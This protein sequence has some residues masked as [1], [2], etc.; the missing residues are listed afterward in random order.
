M[1][2]SILQGQYSYT[3]T[4]IDAVLYNNHG[5]IGKVG[6][7][8]FNGS[9]VCRDDAIIYQ[10]HLDLNWDIRLGSRSSDAMDLFIFLPVVVSDPSVVGWK[11]VY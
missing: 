10:A 3:I 7:C 8:D 11:E 5:T 1:Q 2:D 4:R 6:N 9:I